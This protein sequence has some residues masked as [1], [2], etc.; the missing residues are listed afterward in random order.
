MIDGVRKILRFQT[1]GTAFSIST[2]VFSQTRRNF[3]GIGS[4]HMNGGLRCFA[5]EPDSALCAVCLRLN[6][7]IGTNGKTMI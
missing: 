4:I 3:Y 7:C 2:A 1:K 6:R 5:G